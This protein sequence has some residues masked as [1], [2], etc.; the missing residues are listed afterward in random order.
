MKEF[1][2]TLDKDQIKVISPFLAHMDIKKMEIGSGHSRLYLDIKPE[3]TN[4]ARTVHGGVIATLLDVA[5]GSAAASVV[6]ASELT[7]T[8]SLNVDYIQ[9]ALA[10]DRLVAEGTVVKKGSR[11]VFAEAIVK[12][13]SG[14]IVARGSAVLAIRPRQNHEPAL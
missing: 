2:Q 1:L 8:A 9:S 6:D 13:G 3:H 5:V 7:V 10:G 12:T 4:R 14:E 11:I